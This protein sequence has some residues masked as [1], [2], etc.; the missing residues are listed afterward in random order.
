M[1]ILLRSSAGLSLMVSISWVRFWPVPH[2]AGRLVEESQIRLAKSA[3]FPPSKQHF[4]HDRSFPKPGGNF[5]NERK[6][7]PRRCARWSGPA[8]LRGGGRDGGVLT[9]RFRPRLRLASFA[10]LEKHYR[11]AIYFPSRHMT[12]NGQLLTYANPASV[13]GAFK[14]VRGRLLA[15]LP[16]GFIRCWAAEPFSQRS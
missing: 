4:A 15:T 6:S 8:D 1:P 12:A 5:G 3:K 16:V 2:R 11:H 10:I 13:G 14:P 9:F 7:R